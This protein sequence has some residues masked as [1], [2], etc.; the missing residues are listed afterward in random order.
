MS[1]RAEG[2]R[3]RCSF[4]AHQRRVDPEAETAA[5]TVVE[6]LPPGPTLQIGEPANHARYDSLA[7]MLATPPERRS[8]SLSRL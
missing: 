1:A 5:V 3:Q 8:A 4:A 2:C 7:A 6:S